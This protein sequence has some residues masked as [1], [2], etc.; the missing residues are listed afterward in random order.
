MGYHNTYKSG[1]CKSQGFT[2]NQ[3]GAPI[4]F[5]GVKVSNWTKPMNLGPTVPKKHLHDNVQVICEFHGNI[6]V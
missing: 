5:G 3:I 6:C 4:A 2:D 1:S